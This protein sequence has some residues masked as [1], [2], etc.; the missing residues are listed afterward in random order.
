M[1]HARKNVDATAWQPHAREA[2]ELTIPIVEELALQ[3]GS[4]VSERHLD[5]NLVAEARLIR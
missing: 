5:S 2:A 3:G 1:A 4:C